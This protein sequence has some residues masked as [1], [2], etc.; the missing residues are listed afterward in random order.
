MASL[1]EVQGEFL[2]LCH[3]MLQKANDPDDPYELDPKILTEI[4]RFMASSKIS[5]NEAPKMSPELEEARKKAE[6][7]LKQKKERQ[8]QDTED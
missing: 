8:A 6:K 3:S 2:I 5:D 4:F 1:T 7:L